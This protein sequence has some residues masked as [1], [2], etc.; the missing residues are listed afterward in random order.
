MRAEPKERGLRV[1]ALSLVRR[2]AK[3]ARVSNG[4]YFA[5]GLTMIR[6]VVSRQFRLYSR[7]RDAGTGKRKDV[8]EFDP[9]VKAARPE[10]EVQF[11]KMYS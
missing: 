6:N 5:S 7:K 9:L 3:M 10:S 1:R 2:R 11:F 8:G 4:L